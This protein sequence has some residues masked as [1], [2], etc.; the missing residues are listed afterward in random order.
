MSFRS[1][2]DN[3]RAILGVMAFPSPD[4]IPLYLFETKDVDNFAEPLRFCQDP[5]GFSDDVEVLLTLAL[6][7]RNKEK[8]AFS[9]HRLVQT[10][11]NLFLNPEDRQ[12]N[13]NAA[14]KLVSA[15][16]AREDAENAQLYWSWKLCS[17]YLP[18]VLN[19]RDSFRQERQLNP[20]FSA[21]MECCSLNN[22]CQR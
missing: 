14:S 1:W 9:I 16:F 10:S 15:V 11:Y 8:R 20:K 2:N 3:A 17:R 19:L 22:A 7:K 4:S 6:V 12:E 13:F 21:V 18:Q 5:L